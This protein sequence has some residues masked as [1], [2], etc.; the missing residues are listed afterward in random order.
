MLR[1]KRNTVVEA[2]IVLME[3]G[4]RLDAMVLER[5]RGDGKGC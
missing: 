4:G 2:K 5:R 1:E 3:W